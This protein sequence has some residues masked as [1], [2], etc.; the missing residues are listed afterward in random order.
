MAWLTRF[1]LIVAPAVVQLACRDGYIIIENWGPPAGYAAVQGAIRDASGTPAPNTA[2]SITRCS[3]PI[4]GF[5]GKSIADQQ[6]SYRVDGSLP[7]V[8]VLPQSMLD[9]LHVHCDILLGAPGAATAVD[10]ITLHFAPS[11]DSVVPSVRDLL[12][13]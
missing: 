3:D 13:P 4:G 7:P 11:R 1:S 10:T 12:L 6:G 9:T 8:G 5:F 2:V